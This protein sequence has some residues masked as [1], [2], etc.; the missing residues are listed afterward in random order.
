MTTGSLDALIEED[1]V[2]P[3]VAIAHLFSLPGRERGV[4]VSNLGNHLDTLLIHAWQPDGTGPSTSVRLTPTLTIQR[5]AQ[6]LIA[7]LGLLG[8]LPC[9]IFGVGA[10]G[11]IA[12]EL[13]VQLLGA[14]ERVAGLSL[15]GPSG[16]QALLVSHGLPSTSVA[17]DDLAAGC[18]PYVPLPIAGHLPVN[19]VEVD[20]SAICA[21]TSVGGIALPLSQAARTPVQGLDGNGALEATQLVARAMRSDARDVGARPRVPALMTL[22][23]GTGG[24]SFFCVPGAGASVADFMPLCMQLDRAA[25]IHAFQPRGL[26]DQHLPRT[27]V[28]AAARAYLSEMELLRPRGPVRLVGHSFGAWIAV[29]MALQMQAAGRPPNLLTLIDSEP[30]GPHTR[31]GREYSR[32]DALCKL[33]SLHEESSQ[34]PLPL[35]RADFENASPDRQLVRLHAGM[36][37]VGLLPTRSS[38][39]LL[40][41]PITCFEAALRTRYR[42]KATYNGPTLL[43]LAGSRST[44]E[45]S[46]RLSADMMQSGWA[47]WAPDLTSRVAAGNHMTLL[48]DPHVKA[49]AELLLKPAGTLL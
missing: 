33:V 43:V 34:R 21:P 11:V 9:R 38:P 28:E 46:H 35:A 29:E 13:A 16:A 20:G 44:A 27:T 1:D 45:P 10:A 6:R 14:D 40:H 30:P 8:G 39:E 15:L 31:I 24:P 19:W 5:L 7:E 37:E 4:L 49:I 22:Q 2:H 18:T 26:D 48:K 42:P 41:G 12:Y 17:S 3:A 47:H 23:S 32:V 36:V 25:A